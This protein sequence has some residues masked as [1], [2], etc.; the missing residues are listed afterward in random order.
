MPGRCACT[1][2]FTEKT[3]QKRLTKGGA[4]GIITHVAG[5]KLNMWG[6]SSAGRALAWHARGQRFD[7]AILHQKSTILHVKYGAFLFAEADFWDCI[8]SPAPFSGLCRQFLYNPQLLTLHRFQ[9]GMFAARFLAGCCIIPFNVRRKVEVEG[10]VER[11]PTIN[12]YSADKLIDNHFLCFKTGTV[13]Q[14][15]IGNQLIIQVPV[16]MRFFN[17]SAFLQTVPYMPCTV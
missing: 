10:N 1:V 9:K 15:S 5:H 2:Q 8:A 16:V 17:R 3:L 14:V 6:I 12:I 4:A 13:V 7:P 11:I